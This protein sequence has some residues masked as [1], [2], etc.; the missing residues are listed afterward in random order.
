MSD[1]PYYKPPEEGP[2][3]PEDADGIGDEFETF[4]RA[5]DRDVSDEVSRRDRE[6]MT[7][8]S[9]RAFADNVLR[10]ILE[11]IERDP[12][13]AE[14][15]GL[16]SDIGIEHGFDPETCAEIAALPFDEAF[17]TAYGYLLQAGLDADEVLERFMQ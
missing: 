6:D 13:S 4:L 14:I 10:E 11:R 3:F 2:L 12:V 15:A 16:L 7:E 9:F 1:V 17:E 5:S 8:S